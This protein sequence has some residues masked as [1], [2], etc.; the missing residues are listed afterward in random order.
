MVSHISPLWHCDWKFVLL[1]LLIFPTWL[2]SIL[3]GRWHVVGALDYLLNE[4][5][6]PP[7]STFIPLPCPPSPLLRNITLPTQVSRC[8]FQNLSWLSP[9]Y[10]LWIWMSWVKHKSDH[11]FFLVKFYDGDL[12]RLGERL[13]SYQALTFC[14]HEICLLHFSMF[15]LTCSG[16]C[17]IWCPCLTLSLNPSL[18]TN[19]TFNFSSSFISQF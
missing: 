1:F 4:S 6:I 2:V 13:K 19:K 3:T 17:I 8:H 15:M 10:P 9:I 16:F 12:L 11:V 5:I 14:P 18:P 7:C